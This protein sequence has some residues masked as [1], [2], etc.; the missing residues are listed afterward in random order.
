MNIADIAGSASLFQA[1][2]RRVRSLFQNIEGLAPGEST[3]IIMDEIFTGT[4]EVKYKH[5][6]FIATLKDSAYS[7]TKQKLNSMQQK[8]ISIVSWKTL[9]ECKTITRPHYVERKRL[10]DAL[11]QKIANSG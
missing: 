6:Y 9:E 3:L 7:V 8:E 5:V 1:E 4:N 11:E 10:I 2:M